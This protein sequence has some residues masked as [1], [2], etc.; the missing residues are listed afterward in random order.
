MS[1]RIE[2]LCIGNA[3]VDAFAP[4]SPAWLDGLGI[5]EASQ[6]VSQETAALLAAGMGARARP[7]GSIASGGAAANVAKIASMLGARAAFAGCVGRDELGGFFR[8]ELE[9]A[10]VDALLETGEGPTGACYV[11]DSG[12]GETRIAA[13]LGAAAEFSREHLREGAIA[14]ADA[15]A[16]DGYLLDRPALANAVLRMASRHGIPIALD[17]ASVFHVREKTEAILQYSRTYPLIVFMN[18]DESIMFYSTIRKGASRGGADAE[19]LLGARAAGR[20]AEREKEAFILRE[21]CPVLKCMTEGDIFPVIAIKLGGRG[22]V[23]LAGGNVHRAGTFAVSPKNAVGAGDAFCAAFLSAWIRGMP[24]R[25]CAAF[26]NR[27]AREVLM[28]PG[29]SV[30]AEKLASL[31]RLLPKAPGE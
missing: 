19:G 28:V 13:A 15:V 21:I 8:D 14:G 3:M 30:E 25:E 22:A 27:A 7:G 17:A 6:H 10:G 16:L 4:A 18:A 5:T 11:F 31:S 12:G 9:K 24:I 29:T 26:G 2:L 1:G 20:E 23:V